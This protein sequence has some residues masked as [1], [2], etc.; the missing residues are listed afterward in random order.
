MQHNIQIVEVTHDST[1]RFWGRTETYLRCDCGWE[2]SVPM[3]SK[4]DIVDGE[5]E[6]RIRIHKIDAIAKFCGMKFETET[7]EPRMAND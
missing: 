2:D 6:C 3:Y 5:I 1:K 7:L 4:D